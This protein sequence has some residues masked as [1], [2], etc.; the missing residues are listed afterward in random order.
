VP[1]LTVAL[2]AVFRASVLTVG[3]GQQFDRIEDAVKAARS[4]DTIE[5]HSRANGYVG[6][7][8]IIRISGLHFVGTGEERVVLD[9]S[10]FDFSG[11][12]PIPRA[13]FQ[14][15]PGAD[16]VTI[17]HFE[18]RGAHNESHNGAGVRVNAAKNVSVLDCDIHG[19][20]M[21][22]M[23]NGVVGDATAG[24]GQLFDHCHIHHN[25]D[26][27]DPGYNH[28]L[29]LGG[30]SATVQ[31]CEIDHSLTGHNLKSRARVTEV[32]YCF[33]HDSAN[34]E[35]DFVE[36]WDTEGP[37]TRAIVMGNLIVKDPICIGNRGVI[38]I[39]AEKGKRGGGYDLVN[40]TIV[41][42]FNSPVLA[43][44]SLFMPG[45]ITNNVFVNIK[46]AAADLVSWETSDNPMQIIVPF[47]G[48]WVSKGDS[49]KGVQP[50]SRML[51]GATWHDGPGFPDGDYT[52][53][54]QPTD[55]KPADSKNDKGEIA[56]F[57]PA[58]RY[59]GK[60]KWVPSKERF[61]GAG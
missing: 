28:N 14:V 22:V 34:R 43:L 19:N 3:D 25:G 35:L 36:A 53:V 40:N 24:S 38:H 56:S 57:V 58:F 6:C 7:A 47:G 37:D 52:L 20:D 51:T 8:V 16:G 29:Y 21:G 11:V 31:F 46:Q 9:G 50:V 12:G 2:L 17:E 26:A 59:V 27:K 15:D 60:G 44:S 10:G 23:S 54:K 42:P 49:V 1:L 39:G 55:W 30:T 5:V 41:T 18:L 45:T 13:I 61:I 4:G 32:K 48:N 33:I